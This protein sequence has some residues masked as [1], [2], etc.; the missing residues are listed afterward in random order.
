MSE[1]DAVRRWTR[2]IG[3]LRVRANKRR[4]RAAEPSGGAGDI[5][6]E[7]LE[8]CEALLRELAGAQMVSDHARRE[9]QREAASRQ[10]LFDHLPVASVTTDGGGVIVNANRAAA[11]LLNVSAKHLRGRML[12]HFAEDREGF[13]RLTRRLH[14]GDD[15]V[16][17]ILPVRPRERASL[18]VRALIVGESAPAASSWVWFLVPAT[19]AHPE[20]P[21]SAPAFATGP[22]P[23]AG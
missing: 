22:S 17:A 19:D 20:I 5:V 2:Q 3:L 7:A 10:L 14:A 23:E 4:P 6:T 12:L 1:T 16:T 9:M 11:A 21:L 18:L 15:H 13:N 8:A